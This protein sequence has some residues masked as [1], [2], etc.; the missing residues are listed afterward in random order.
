M[1]RP[2]MTPVTLPVLPGDA[3]MFLPLHN[4]PTAMEVSQNR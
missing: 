1:K 2:L 3:A 4:L